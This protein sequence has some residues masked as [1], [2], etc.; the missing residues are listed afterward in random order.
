[1]IDGP[2]NTPASLP[3]DPKPPAPGHDRLCE[4]A[5]PPPGVR[6]PQAGTFCHCAARANAR[7]PYRLPDPLLDTPWGLF[8][9][10]RGHPDTR[11][12]DTAP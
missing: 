9:F 12:H 2:Q 8:D 3:P 7:Q 4:I 10:Q 1:V 6:E 5:N 11:G